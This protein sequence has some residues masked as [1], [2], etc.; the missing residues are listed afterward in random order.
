[1]YPERVSLW[2]NVW[3]FIYLYPSIYHGV[4]ISPLRA[5]KLFMSVQH[6]PSFPFNFGFAVERRARLLF[7]RPAEDFGGTGRSVKG[8]WGWGA[9]RGC[10]LATK[11]SCL[12]LVSDVGWSVL[13]ELR[14][15]EYGWMGWAMVARKTRISCVRRKTRRDY[16]LTYTPTRAVQT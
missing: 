15:E 6:L 11:L 1:M 2:T 5:G 13:K 9:R 7:T 14:E 4:S 3:S 8:R 12:M 10:Y 16:S